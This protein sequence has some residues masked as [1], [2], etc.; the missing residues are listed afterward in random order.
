MSLLFKAGAGIIT[1]GERP[2]TTA[3]LLLRTGQVALSG[4]ARPTKT[5]PALNNKLILQ[6]VMIGPK[7]T[8][9]FYGGAELSKKYAKT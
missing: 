1:K 2:L 9:K 6:F 4:I 7:F 5:I 8:R 3:P